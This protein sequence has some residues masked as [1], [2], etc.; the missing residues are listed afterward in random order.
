MPDSKKGKDQMKKDLVRHQELFCTHVRK[1]A[2]VS[3]E[4]SER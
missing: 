2:G 4:I 3:A 1:D